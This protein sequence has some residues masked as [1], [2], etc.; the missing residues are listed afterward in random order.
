MKRLHLADGFSLPDAA[1]T[2]TFALLAI[3]G[4]GKTNAA[5][6][7][8]EEMF[9]A[10][11]PFVAIDPVGSWW[12]LRAG[13]E[14]KQGGL[15]I[16]VL[17]GDH[18]DV[19]LERT[20]GNL[21]ADL[22]VDQNLSC[23]LDLSSF[24]SEAAKRQF[25][26]DFARRL[27][28]R[29]RTPRHLFLEECDDYLPQRPGRDQLA[30]L[31]AWEAI[32]RRGRSRGLGLT[33]ITQRSAV[34]NKNVLTQVG[35]LITLRTTA[36]QDRAAVEAWVE[37]NGAKREILE[38]LPTLQSGEAWVWS[39]HF[40]GETKRIRF[41]LSSTFDSGATPTLRGGGKAPATLADVDLA[42]LQERMA[43]TI[44]RAKADD[45]KAL[46]A[47]IANLQKQLAAR[48]ATKVE[49]VEVPAVTDKQMAQVRAMADA[50]VAAAEALRDAAGQLR[51]AAGAAKQVPVTRAAVAAPAP[52]AADAPAPDHGDL[53]GPE[54]RILDAIA[55]LEATNQQSEQD[56]SAVAFLAGY[57]VG[58]GAYNN[59]RGRLHKRGLLEYRG[60][61]LALTDAGRAIA[62]FPTEALTS[63]QIHARIMERL[64]GPERRILQVL[65]DAFPAAVANDDLA[66]RAAYEPGGGAFNN[67]RGRLR[68]LGL[69]EYPD[70]GQV[71]ARPVLFAGRRE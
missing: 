16:P 40:L 27:Y 53:D 50:A 48:P 68:T 47:E 71:R 42:A 28:A 58:G 63:E 31:G 30:L 18:G 52:R 20:G 49:R 59:P 70:R 8:A 5:R 64:D 25:L 55:W 51:A 36:P 37:H 2:E 43:A 65:I 21:V 62:T 35:T 11:A 9:A 45:P 14:G 60:G 44:E 24:E 15:P 56:Q 67:P 61:D 69:I 34:V 22:V 57:R 32:V 33:L 12:G 10:G 29:N 23:V 39:P 54:R 66:R 3:R 7:M 13:R 46:R 26:L 41:R 17:G 38:S 6:V 19:P 1:V 4:A